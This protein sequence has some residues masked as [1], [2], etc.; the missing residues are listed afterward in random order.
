MLTE[1]VEPLEMIRNLSGPRRSHPAGRRSAAGTSSKPQCEKRL[2][3]D[4]MDLIL[5]LRSPA[6][7][8]LPPSRG[9]FNL[10]SHIIL[11]E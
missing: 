10:D 9:I 5:L 3:E 6:G 4:L 7:L 2:A 11:Y 8:E 1:H